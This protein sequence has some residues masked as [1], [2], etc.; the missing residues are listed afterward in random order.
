[1]KSNIFVT[2]ELLIAVSYNRHMKLL[3]AKQAAE[4]LG[5]NASRV[6]QLISAG[7]L[8]STLIGNSHVIKESDL[9]L[10]ANRRGRGRPPRKGGRK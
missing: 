5:V 8:P 9:K 7:K 10:V 4:A 2:I 6:R 1:V 3:S